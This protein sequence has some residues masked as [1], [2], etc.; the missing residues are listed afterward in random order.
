MD[1]YFDRYTEER[2]ERADRLL[3]ERRDREAEE[4]ANRTKTDM[5]TTEETTTLILAG[6]GYQLTISPEAEKRKAELLETASAVTAVGDNDES[7]RAQ[8]VS[9][10][11]AALR[12]ETEKSRKAVKEPVNRIGKLIDST[13]KSFI[14]DVEAEEKRIAGLVGEHAREVARRKA[15]AERIE[16]EKMEEA[17]RAREE[18][19]RAAAQ[20]EAARAGKLSIAEIAAAKQ[21]E[22]AAEAERRATLEARMDASADV[23]A[24]KI[25]DGVRFAIDFEVTDAKRLLF[26]QPNLVDLVV[27]RSDTLAYLKS[28]ESEGVDIESLGTALGLRVFKKPVVSSR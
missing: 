19:E 25:A 4:W 6:D 16:R 18:A 28:M 9:R 17:R 12:I 14:A 24:A 20:A 8:V 26:E 22:A 21:A 7:A 10:A 3:D 23:A 5:S 1:L 15:E 13:A 11:L 2:I 27:R